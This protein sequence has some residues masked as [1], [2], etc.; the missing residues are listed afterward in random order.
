MD[1]PITPAPGASAPAETSP[2]GQ[3]GHSALALRRQIS[4]ARRRLIGVRDLEARLVEQGRRL[5][6]LTGRVDRQSQLIDRQRDLL[7]RLEQRIAEV[8]RATGVAA[9]HPA[10][11]GTWSEAGR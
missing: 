6:R 10:D 4:R 7:D 11:P 1:D 2:A 5:T 3:L 8:E 9:R